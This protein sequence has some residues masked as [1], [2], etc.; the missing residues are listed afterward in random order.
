L[1]TPLGSRGRAGNL[2]RYGL[3]DCRHA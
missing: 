2:R 1:L 3:P